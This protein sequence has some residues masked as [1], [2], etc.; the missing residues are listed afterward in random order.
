[1][2]I[3]SQGNPLE[4]PS[5]QSLLPHKF[6]RKRIREISG[7]HGAMQLSAHLCRKREIHWGSSP[8]LG[9]KYPLQIRSIDMCIEF[10]IIFQLYIVI[11]RGNLH[12]AIIISRSAVICYIVVRG[13]V[14]RFSSFGSS[15]GP[16]CICML[17][18]YILWIKEIE[19]DLG[20]W[21]LCPR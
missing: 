14:D 16:S 19:E 6:I 8:G 12:M 5:C 18:L 9:K 11:K 17:Y 10:K 15:T 1:M 21:A 3:P 4:I 20:I 2:T 7:L 13:L